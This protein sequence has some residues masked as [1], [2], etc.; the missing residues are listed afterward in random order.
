M[1]ASD[2]GEDDAIR[3]ENN[4]EVYVDD[5]LVDEAPMAAGT[6]ADA[7]HH[8]QTQLCSPDQLVVGLRCNGGDVSSDQMAETLPKPV[9]EFAR[10]DVLTG[11]R[12]SLVADA[13][14]QAAACLSDTEAAVQRVAELLSEGNA[15]EGIDTLGECLRVWQQ[16]HDAVGKSIEM[17]QID[18]DQVEV[19]EATLM[20]VIG[21]PKGVL[22]QVRDALQSRDHVL[23]ADILKYEFMAV[24]SEWH[25]VITRLRREADEQ[26][27]A[28][29][30]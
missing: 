10:L 9:S 25:S 6:V 27:P 20:E 17:L 23:L 3:K 7:I 13:M 18:P 16:I 1:R 21:R 30:E 8:V 15:V 24:T 5:H 4:V 26:Q 11:T 19:G 22:V 12:F 14:A 2:P 29:S 28:H